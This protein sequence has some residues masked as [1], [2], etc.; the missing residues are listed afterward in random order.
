MIWSAPEIC[1]E[2]PLARAGMSL[3]Y[4]PSRNLLLL[5]GGSG[6]SSKTFEDLHAAKPSGNYFK[7][8]SSSFFLFVKILIDVFCFNGL[9]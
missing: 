7:V 5:F 9:L 3:S 4:V 2:V 8:Q 1:G 6:S